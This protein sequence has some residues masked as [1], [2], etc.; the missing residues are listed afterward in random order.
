MLFCW[1]F[2]ARFSS[3][4]FCIVVDVFITLNSWCSFGLRVYFIMFVRLPTVTYLS[5]FFVF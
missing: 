4:S 2:G 5:F 3:F 1:C